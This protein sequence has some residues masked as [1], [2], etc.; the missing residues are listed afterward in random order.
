M[1]NWTAGY[2]WLWWVVKRTRRVP[3][4]ERAEGSEPLQVTTLRPARTVP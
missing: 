1:I 2:L 4:R 3:E